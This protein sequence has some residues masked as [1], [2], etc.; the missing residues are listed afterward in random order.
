[1]KDVLFLLLA[2]PILLFYKW[3]DDEP[4]HTDVWYENNWW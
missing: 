3:D 1:M 4:D 2:I